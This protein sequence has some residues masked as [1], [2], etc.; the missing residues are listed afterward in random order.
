MISK[1][2]KHKAD[3]TMEQCQQH[4]YFVDAGDQGDS[5]AAPMIQALFVEVIGIINA[6]L[7]LLFT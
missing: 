6:Y 7:Y 2:N 3:A 4:Y 1:A 5:I